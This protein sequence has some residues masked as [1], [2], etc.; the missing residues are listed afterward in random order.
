MR[1]NYYIWISESWKQLVL[2]MPL[3][4]FYKEGCDYTIINMYVTVPRKKAG[5]LFIRIKRSLIQNDTKIALPAIFYPEII[6]M[7]EGTVR[8]IATPWAPSPPS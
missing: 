3:C 8:S 2:L 7:F 4:T 5:T 6:I 1:L